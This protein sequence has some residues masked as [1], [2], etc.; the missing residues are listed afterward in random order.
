MALILVTAKREAYPRA[1]K[2][3][4]RKSD[5]FADPTRAKPSRR[6]TRQEK[7]GT[8]VVWHDLRQ[9]RETGP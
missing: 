3:A 5:S 6:H 8:P 2:I 9:N 4:L 1:E 7:F